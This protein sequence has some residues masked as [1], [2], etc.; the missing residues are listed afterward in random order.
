MIQHCVKKVD[1]NCQ[2]SQNQLFNCAKNFTFIGTLVVPYVHH[3]I[4]SAKARC[5]ET[6]ANFLVPK[7]NGAPEANC[8]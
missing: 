3:T 6:G 5:L 8:T 2:T 7:L 1:H 4:G